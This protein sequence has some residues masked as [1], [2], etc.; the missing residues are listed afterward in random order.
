MSVPKYLGLGVDIRRLIQKV[1]CGTFQK[2][3]PKARCVGIYWCS[4]Y[5]IYDRKNPVLGYF[6]ID[7]ALTCI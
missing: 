1:P 7:S 3:M 5:I 2:N 6:E 4:L